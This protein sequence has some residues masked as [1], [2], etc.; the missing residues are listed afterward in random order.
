[1]P[2]RQTPG[3]GAQTTVLQYSSV[4]ARALVGS[5]VVGA[6]SAWL[7]PNASATAV[8][9]ANAS[10]AIPLFFIVVLPIVV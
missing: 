10:P 8:A 6:A 9:P 7:A 3:N 4:Q 5:G 2:P 1:L